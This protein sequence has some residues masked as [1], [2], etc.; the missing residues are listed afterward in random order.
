MKRAMAMLLLISAPGWASARSVPAAASPDTNSQEEQ[1]EAVARRVFDDIF[2]QGKFRVADEIY[3]RDFV[4]HGV[5]GD[6]GLAEDQ[7]A[8]HWE[9]TAVPDLHITVDL[10][11]ASEDTVTVVWTARG[12]NT[13]HAG[14]MPATGAQIEERGIT[15]WRIVDGRI[16][17]EWTS[18]DELRLLRQVATQLWWLEIC[19][20]GVLLLLD[21]GLT[22]LTGKLWRMVRQEKTA[23]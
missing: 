18:F 15:V 9:K 4:N 14:W 1:N 7:A 22:W 11:T 23:A 17:D 5:H 12:R 2:N 6:A 20:V 13:R 10:M 16:H 21:W 3:A 8:V 19:L